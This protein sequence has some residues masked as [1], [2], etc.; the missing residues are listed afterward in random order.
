MKK[1][2]LEESRLVSMTD[3]ELLDTL[4]Y[5]WEETKRIDEAMK[6]DLEIQRLEATLKEYKDTNYLDEKRAY[7]GKLKAVRAH[8]KIRGLNFKTPT[9]TSDE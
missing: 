5:L 1:L 6:A 8:A 2:I 4:G 3:Q 7:V 9:R